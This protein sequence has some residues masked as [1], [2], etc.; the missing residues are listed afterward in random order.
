MRRTRV[1]AVGGSA[2]LVVGLVVGCS[3]RGSTPELPPVGLD[4]LRP[5]LPSWAQGTTP[6]PGTELTLPSGTSM[7][8]TLAGISDDRRTI[9]VA[10]VAGDGDCVTHLGYAV[11]T[12]GSTLVLA[13]YS[14]SPSVGRACAAGLGVGLETVRLPLALDGPVRLVHAPT[15]GGTELP[16]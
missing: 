15:T 14:T 3:A 5:S 8:W 7:P 12:Q 16:G 11:D 13:E 6:S 1:V 2:A 10:F 9:T 4:P